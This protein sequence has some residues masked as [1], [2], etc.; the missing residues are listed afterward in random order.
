[1]FQKNEKCKALKECHLMGNIPREIS[2]LVVIFLKKIDQ[3]SW[4]TTRRNY[5][6]IPQI[7]CIS[8]RFRVLHLL[9]WEFKRSEVLWRYNFILVYHLKHVKSADLHETILTPVICMVVMAWHYFSEKFLSVAPK[10]TRNWY[11]SYIS[12][13][14]EVKN[15]RK[16]RG[17][18]LLNARKH[19]ESE[20]INRNL[21]A[22]VLHVKPS[23]NNS[24]LN[25]IDISL[26]RADSGSYHFLVTGTKII[27]IIW[28]LSEN[29]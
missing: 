12:A 10:K 8:F 26:Q 1:M 18:P 4:G 17:K 22:A 20:S 25:D 28:K 6:P 24:N 7:V 21:S 23:C 15:N 2:P 5:K 16:K 14:S 11:F 27:R 9:S 3:P 13:H 29:C 19:W